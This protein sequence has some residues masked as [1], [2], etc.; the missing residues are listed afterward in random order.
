MALPRTYVTNFESIKKIDDH[1]VAITAK[2]IESLFPCSMSYLLMVSRCKAE[3]LKYDW[4]A[5]ANAPSGTGP[6]RFGRM[7]AH[8]R[9][10]L[11]PNKDC[12]D[13]KRIPKADDAADETARNHERAGHDDLGRARPEPAGLVAKTERI[14]PGE[15]LVSGP[16]ADRRDP[17]T[18][19]HLAAPD[20]RHFQRYM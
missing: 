5:Y 16:H 3:A 1:T 8:E 20:T 15:K 13:P 4:A 17:V 11:L 14:R 6:Y 2:V 7:V 12:W 10:E 18:S 19:E 9:L